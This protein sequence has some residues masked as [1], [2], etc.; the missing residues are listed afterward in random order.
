[1]T[2]TT[3]GDSSGTPYLAF[4]P[5]A[6]SQVLEGFKR[7]KN[8]DG[9][10]SFLRQQFTETKGSQEIL[11]ALAR[12]IQ[13]HETWRPRPSRQGAALEA[14]VVSW[15]ET[16]FRNARAVIWAIQ[17]QLNEVGASAARVA[18]EHGLYA[19]VLAKTKDSDALL[20]AR[21][22]RAKRDL[23]RAIEEAGVAEALGPLMSYVGEV[24]AVPT[25]T[26]ETNW[27]N[28]VK[29]VSEK[30]ETG[31]TIYGL[32]RLLSFQVHPSN[33]NSITFLFDPNS[34][35]LPFAPTTNIAHCALAGCIWSGW[36]LESILQTEGF[37]ALADPI[38]KRYGILHIERNAI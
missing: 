12:V 25:A 35:P 5:D 22:S 10:M 37:S 15:A 33:F 32:Y 30:V 20:E 8:H 14:M 13:Y 26:P 38:A 34:D 28:R 21:E 27:A 2:E 29:S 16:A 4:D 7:D 9:I 19:A 23:A 17:N 11:D 1:M 3:P 18:L 24:L 31:G 36:S 6:L